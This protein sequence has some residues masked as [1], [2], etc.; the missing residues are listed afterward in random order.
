MAFACEDTGGSGA[1]RRR[2]APA[3][4]MCCAWAVLAPLILRTG[5][6]SISQA[7][8]GA[9]LLVIPCFS[10]PSSSSPVPPALLGVGVVFSPGI[11]FGTYLPSLKLGLF[12]H[13]DVLL[14]FHPLCP[15]PAPGC[16][17]RL[18]VRYV[19][20]IVCGGRNASSGWAVL[21]CNTVWETVLRVANR[22]SHHT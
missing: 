19:R 17:P 20:C 21:N 8:E 7:G 2:Y 16:A 10:F 12:E 13:H 9:S 3:V 18:P 22:L 6:I 11:H 14:V 5:A 4:S 15:Q 1:A